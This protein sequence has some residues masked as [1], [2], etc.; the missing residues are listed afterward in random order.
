M[1]KLVLAAMFAVGF[2]SLGAPKANAATPTD[3]IAVTVTL[4]SIISVI[5]DVPSWAIGAKALSATS[6]SDLVTA[7]NDGN[8]A[9]KFMIKGANGAGLWTL[10]AVIGEDIFALGFDTTDAY[11]T[12]VAIDTTGVELAASVAVAGTQTFKMQYSMPSTNTKTVGLG[13]GFDVTVTASA[14]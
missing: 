11:E 7:T 13:Q 9:E 6:I 1:T 4:D 12:F 10:G 5:V 8:V 14:P 3:T 2:I